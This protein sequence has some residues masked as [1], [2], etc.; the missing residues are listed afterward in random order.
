MMGDS[1]DACCRA[2]ESGGADVIG[3]NC[4]L[5]SADMIELASALRAATGRPILIQPNAG[6][7]SLDAEGRLSYAQTPEAF[8]ADMLKIEAAGVRFLGGCCG[9][10]PE[11]IRCLARALGRS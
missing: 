8:A 5:M 2:L 7:P 11:T 10:T 3:A 4:T 9:T 6:Q 1:L